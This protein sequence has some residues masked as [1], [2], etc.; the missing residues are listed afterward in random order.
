MALTVDFN[1]DEFERSDLA[2]RQGLDNRVTLDS[3]VEYNL[4]RLCRDVLQPLRDLLGVPVRI[5]SGY[6]S[7]VVNVLV[8]GDPGSAHVLGLAANF[9]A[10]EYGTPHEVARRA[11]VAGLPFEQLLVEYGEWVHVSVPAGDAAPKRE[12]LTTTRG[13]H[14]QTIYIPGIVRFD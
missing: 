7:R 4:R 11:E 14:G 5:T 3:P 13:A 10:P 9:I 6:R 12:V 2:T 8:G 1:L